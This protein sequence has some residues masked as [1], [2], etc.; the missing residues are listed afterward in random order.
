VPKQYQPRANAN[1][2]LWIKLNQLNIPNGECQNTN[3]I[4]SV[5][6]QKVH[7]VAPHFRILVG[8]KSPTHPSFKA[9]L[10]PNKDNI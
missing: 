4:F 2:Y 5:V 9:L 7:N 1:F 10:T 6:A 8:T 3:N